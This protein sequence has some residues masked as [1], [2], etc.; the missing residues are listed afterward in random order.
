MMTRGAGGVVHFRVVDKETGEGV[1]GDAEKLS[2]WLIL[3][4]TIRPI[5]G[6][7]VELTGYAAPAGWY[8]VTLTE[9]ETDAGTITICG[10]STTE[11][12]IVE[13][14][15][16][17]TVDPGAIWDVAN[18]EYSYGERLILVERR[19]GGGCRQAKADGTTEIYGDDGETVLRIM[20]FSEDASYRYQQGG[21]E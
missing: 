13:P 3:D 14:V 18:G 5:Q 9:T 11:G 4:G 20:R 10:E 19:L 1:P 2:I 12:A 7:P 8:A 15:S 6:T 16:L 21:E 17:S